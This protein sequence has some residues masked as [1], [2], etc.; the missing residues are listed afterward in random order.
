MRGHDS[1]ENRRPLMEN[2]YLN[3]VAD[4][5]ANLSPENVYSKTVFKNSKNYLGVGSHGDVANFTKT[6]KN[7]NIPSQASRLPVANG[8]NWNIESFNKVQ[9]KIQ[10]ALNQRI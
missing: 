3:N 2:Q 1:L 6:T 8:T 4:N 5:R 7:M 10:S 9:Q